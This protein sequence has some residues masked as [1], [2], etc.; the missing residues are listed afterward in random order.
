MV[1]KYSKLDMNSLHIRVYSYVSFA[2]NEDNTS[3]LVYVILLADKRN[4][5]HVLSYWTKKSKRMARSIMAEEAFA[6]SA[7]FDQVYVLRHNL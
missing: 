3:Q 2:S 7:A 5:F 1:L 4:N 6:F